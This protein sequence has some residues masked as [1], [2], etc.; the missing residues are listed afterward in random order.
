[1]SCGSRDAPAGTLTLTITLGL[2]LTGYW[3]NKGLV[4]G[5]NRAGADKSGI[6]KTTEMLVLG[7]AWKETSGKAW[8]VLT[9]MTE[10][11]PCGEEETPKQRTPLLLP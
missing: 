7:E 1:M 6:T 4:L 5:E 8:R 9:W 2:E 3:T 10:G 11:W